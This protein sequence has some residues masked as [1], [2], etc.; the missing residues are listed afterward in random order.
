MLYTEPKGEEFLL[1]CFR[2]GGRRYSLQHYS[3]GFGSVVSDE[4]ER[5]FMGF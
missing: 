2:R 5:D 1:N 3:V 4:I